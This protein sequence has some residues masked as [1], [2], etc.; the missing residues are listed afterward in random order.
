LAA[1]IENMRQRYAGE[2]RFTDRQLGLFFDSLREQGLWDESLI[3]L[4]SDHGESFG[5]RGFSGHGG[6]NT[7]P[8]VQQVP[9]ALKPPASWNLPPRAIDT[10]VSTFDVLPTTLALLGL[11]PPRL[12]AGTDLSNLIRGVPGERAIAVVSAAGGVRHRSLSCFDWPWQLDVRI[13]PEGAIES[14]TLYNLAIDP[15]Q[16]L[17]LSR[18][19]PRVVERLEKDLVEYIKLERRALVQTQQTQFDAQTLDQLRRLGYLE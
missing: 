16:E 12:A 3:W 11:P 8:S 5:E 9:L 19:H 17:D 1:G 6:W 13:T 14:R 15:D 18:A 10:P 4:L 7:T 2:L